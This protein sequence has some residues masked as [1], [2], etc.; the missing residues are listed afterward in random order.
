MYAIYLGGFRHVTLVGHRLLAG[1][2][3]THPQNGRFC[4][5]TGGGLVLVE[6]CRSSQVQ[7][8]LERSVGRDRSVDQGEA[9]LLGAATTSTP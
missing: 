7:Q 4:T 3:N 9:N 1:P 5:R 8:P 6:I 2:E